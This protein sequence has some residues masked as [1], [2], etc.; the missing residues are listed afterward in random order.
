MKNAENQKCSE[1]KIQEY[2]S[3]ISKGNEK[4]LQKLYHATAH[5]LFLFAMSYVQNKETAE[6][7]VQ[8]TFIKII[9][10]IDQYQEQGH[11][12]VWIFT[13]AKNLCKNQLT[14]SK[15]LPEITEIGKEMDY[16]VVELSETL[17]IL[18]DVERQVIRFHVFAGLN[19]KEIAQLLTLPLGKIRYAKRSATKKL[20]HYY[21]EK[22]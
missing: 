11:A 20:K 14:R 5:P 22:K 4:A 19:L 10:N 9:S 7:I 2:L 13:V 17:S 18:S 8:D 6:D 15:N 3:Q 12:K 16:S 1:S 21:L